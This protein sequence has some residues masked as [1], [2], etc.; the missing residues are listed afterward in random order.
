MDDQAGLWASTLRHMA[1]TPPTPKATDAAGR[2]TTSFAN[3]PIVPQKRRISMQISARA[4]PRT[5]SLD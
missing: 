3:T 4:L 5:E 2:N 1:N